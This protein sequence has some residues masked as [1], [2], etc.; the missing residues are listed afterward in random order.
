MGP[1][2]QAEYVLWPTFFGGRGIS[3]AF[4]VSIYRYLLMF[5]KIQKILV[6]LCQVHQN[7]S[8]FI[9]VDVLSSSRSLLIH[10]LG[11]SMLCNI[12]IGISFALFFLS[13][14]TS[15]TPFSYYLWVSC[16]WINADA[17]KSSVMRTIVYV[18]RF[19]LSKRNTKSITALCWIT[20]ST[21]FYVQIMEN[22]SPRWIDK[23][24]ISR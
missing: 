24:I 16:K 15:F 12:F 14:D 5:N 18:F 17:Y 21:G 11:M 19:C 7:V 8:L 22:K 4:A 13:P 20:H 23:K 3:V 9:D 2:A 1:T 6:Y 10:S